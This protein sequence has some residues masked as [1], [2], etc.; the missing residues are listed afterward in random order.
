MSGFY[1]NPWPQRMSNL[2]AERG[3]RYSIWGSYCTIPLYP[4]NQWEIKYYMYYT[5]DLP[6]LNE[7][8]L[9]KNKETSYLDDTSADESTDIIIK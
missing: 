3:L 4:P 5:E 8:S 7:L 6:H 1:F 9:K 2:M